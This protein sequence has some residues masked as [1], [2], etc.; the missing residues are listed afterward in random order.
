M[1]LKTSEKHMMKNYG[2]KKIQSLK[3]MVLK[4]SGKNIFHIL[5]ENMVLKRC[6]LKKHGLKKIWWKA[7]FKSSL[8]LESSKQCRF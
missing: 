8:S 3:N 6:G 5:K 7:M 1:F 2:L 4:T